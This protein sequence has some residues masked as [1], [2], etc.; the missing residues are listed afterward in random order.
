M[1]RS[2]NTCSQRRSRSPSVVE[3]VRARARAASQPTNGGDREPAQ[4]RR[5][6]AAARAPRAARP[7]RRRPACGTRSTSVR[8][9]DG[10][11]AASSAAWTRSSCAPVRDDRPRCHPGCTGRGAP[12]SRGASIAPL[13]QQVDDLVH[14]VGGDRARGPAPTGQR[15][16]V[17]PRSTTRTWTGAP[18]AGQR[19][20]VVR[21]RHRV[22]DDARVAERGAAEQRVEPA[23]QV[24]VAAPVAGRAW[25]GGR[26]PRRPRGRRARRRRGRRRSPASD[27]R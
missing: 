3:V 7:S 25:R 20:A 16:G 24:R 26:R 11:P 17:A 5:R 19:P 4:P 13:S 23:Q 8:C 10:T 15:R 2:V 21:G 18:A 12:P 1:P 9:T 14:D 6:G 27:R 22:H